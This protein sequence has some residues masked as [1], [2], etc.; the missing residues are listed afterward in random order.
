MSAVHGIPY[1]NPNGMARPIPLERF[2]PD[3]PV[4]VVKQYFETSDVKPGLTLDLFGS[5]PLLS[6]E[7]A[8]A[9]KQVLV[10]CNNPILVFMLKML[11]QP[12]K[13]ERFLILLS[14]IASQ[15]RGS[16]RL[17][18][19]LKGVYQTRCGV[20]HTL[21]Q[22]NGYLWRRTE[23]NPYARVYHC[24]NCGDEGERQITD[25]DL[26]ILQPLQRGEPIHRGRALSRVLQGQ[27][28][29]RPAVEE[30]L[31]IYNARALYVLFTL[32]NKLEGMALSPEQRSL[33]E[34]LMISLLDAGTSLWA[35][36]S[37]ADQ[38]RQLTIPAVYFEKNLWTE[39]ENCID[40][41]SQPTPAIELTV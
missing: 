7:A 4:G 28:E 6:L 23:S 17:E 3:C 12:T 9:G 2:L 10:T 36:P 32:L 24:P 37:L 35:W 38:P 30:A 14:D 19:H 8:A 1:F 20:C 16:E 21:I 29:E 27:E 13:K 34:A 11:A 25:E 18:T 15:I 31:K 26:A 33:S 39:L 5:N 40:L 22:T 41:W